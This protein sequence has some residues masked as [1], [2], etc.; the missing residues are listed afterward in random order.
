MWYA[1]DQIEDFSIDYSQCE[2]L[3]SSDFF[4][5][6]PSNFTTYHFKSATLT[7]VPKFSWKLANDNSQE[8]EDERKVCVVQFEVL[9]NMK[10]PIYF[11]YR[12]HN[13]YANHRRFVKSF[14]EDQL[15]GKAASLNDIKNTVGQNCQPLSTDSQGRKIYPCGLI[16]NSLFNDTY[17][18][19]FQGVNGTSHDY[20]LT[21]KGI[22]WATDKDRFKKTK[23]NHTEVVPPPNWFKMFPNGYNETN[24]PDISTWYEFQNWMHPSGL[25]TFN[26]LALRNDNDELQAGIYEINI[27]LHFPVLPYNGQKFIYVSQRSVIGGKNNFL[28]I[29]WMVG[30]GVCFILGLA[31]LVINF[32]KPR[33]TGDVNLLSWNQERM[34]RDEQSAALADGTTSGFEKRNST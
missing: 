32:I 24:L 6:I 23:Y 25:P 8:F 7:N 12:L 27:G 13:F 18:S 1:S 31:L 29:S 2:N 10:G 20:S 30:G 26:K 11:F 16:A 3:A 21:N 15:N 9:N 22:A 33:K 19:T 14:S 5:E 28:G 17:S 34:Q 4:S